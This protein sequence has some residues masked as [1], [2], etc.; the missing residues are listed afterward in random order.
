MIK[1]P[2]YLYIV[3]PTLDLQYRQAWGV[4]KFEITLK[5]LR[6]LSVHISASYHVDILQVLKEICNAFTT[7]AVSLHFCK[8]KR[9]QAR[10]VVS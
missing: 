7:A 4:Q 6:S 10:G 2:C 9:S 8:G 1:W 5:M 3:P